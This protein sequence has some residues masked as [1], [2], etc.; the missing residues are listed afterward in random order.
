MIQ[1]LLLAQLDRVAVRHRWL[2][3][4]QFL[5]LV[6]LV[7]ALA[8]GLLLA[9]KLQTASSAAIPASLLVVGAI[10]LAGVVI[11][12][13][14]ASPRNYAWLASRVEAAF[15]ELH[16]QLLAAIQQRPDLHN[17]EFGYL[18]VSVMRDALQHAYRN[19]WGNIVS[20]QKLL[21]G[22]LANVVTFALFLVIFFATL[23]TATTPRGSQPTAAPSVILPLGQEFVMAVEPGTTE[24]ERGTSLLVLARIQGRMPSE[25][26]LHYSVAT[27]EEQVLPM[28][29]SLADPVFGGRIP[30]VME[31][32]EYFVT[33]D[34]QSSPK[35][36]VT[37][38]EYPKL[39]RADAKLVYPQYTGLEEKLIQDVRTVSAV[40]G[41]KLTLQFRLNKSVASARL[42]NSRADGKGD[43]IELVAS[44]TEPLIYE[45]SLTLQQSRRLKLELVDDAG[46][47]NQKQDQFTINVLPNSP[48]TLK[49]TFPARDVEVSALE[50]LDIRASVMDDFGVKRV[51]LTYSIAG[52]PLQEIVLSEQAAAKQKHELVHQLRL[53]EMKAEP[54]QL[55]SYY[56]WAE[57][58]DP[59]G[60]VRRTQSDMYFAEVR[61]FEEIFRQ[62][63]Q[64]PSGQQQRQQQQQQQG[65]G[66]NAQDAQQ[67]AK[68]Q[69]DIINATWKIIRREI[70][71]QLTPAFAGDVEQIRLSQAA[72][73]EQATALAEKLEDEKS[74]A[75]V[76]A[77]L[78]QMQ[79]ATQQLQLAQDGPVREPLPVAL[80]AEQ[81]AYQALLKLR[82]REHEVTRQQ[83]QQQQGQQSSQQSRSQ[84][85]REQLQQLDLKEEENRYETQ[86]AA[87]EQQQQESAADREN[88]QVL[89]RLRELAQRQHDL[90][91][92]LKELQSALEEAQTPAEKE[93]IRRQLQRLQDEERQILQDTDELQA[94]LDQ[95][96]NQERMAEQ[97]QQLDE[98]RD[99]V[100]RAS[101]AL[102]Q[103]KVGQAAAAGTRAEQQFEE[104][105]EEFRRRAADRFS[106]EVQQL[107]Q[108][109]RELEQKEQEVAE[110][111]KETTEVKKPKKPSLQE[112]ESSREPL[113][114]ELAEQRKRLSSLQD[115]MRETIERAEATEPILSERL[116]ETARNL[117]DQKIEQ[118]LQATERSVRQGLNQDAQKQEAVAGEGLRQLREGIERA[119]EGVL[120]D[121]TEA[122]RR[123]REELQ[124]LSRE[125]NQEL[126]REA[127]SPAGDEQGSPQP[128]QA[129]QPMSGE[130]SKGEQGKGQSKSG[131]PGEQQSG[132]GEGKKGEGQQGD[133]GKGQGGQP[134]EGNGGDG[135]PKKGDPGQGQ[136]PGQGQG[137]GGP[138]EPKQGEQG[139]GAA[140]GEAKG[141]QGKGS[142][143]GQGQPGN[144]PGR[145][146]QQGEQSGQ[147][148]SQQAGQQPG[149]RSGQQ[150]QRGGSQAN[151]SGGLTGPYESDGQEQAGPLTGER[152][153]EWS[154]RL[155]DVE[156]MVGD[157]ELRA[158]AARIR[159]R[160]RAVRAES[161]RHSAPPNWDLVREQLVNPLAELEQRVAEEVLKRTSK[162][163]LVPLDRD[164]V[165]PQYSE[166]TRK[167]YERLGSGK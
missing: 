105:R 61:P 72:A 119:A 60:K 30:V 36:R 26:T 16:T 157:P 42:T 82:A 155:R 21:V 33:A 32:L 22:A 31:P 87:Q 19:Q 28:P 152:F 101:E 148:Q 39:E 100:R 46:R 138:G 160:A 102:Q 3:L 166:K 59:S 8:G 79:R 13:T 130:P 9:W 25:A 109:A 2:R 49:P 78:E 150:N 93:E 64:P 113:A 122:L 153:R 134:G 136:Q 47:K 86:R 58:H 144:N 76:E 18:Q 141:G 90:N 65:Q 95:P 54:D 23:F 27:G 132:K 11:W 84:Q 43:P 66:Q 70:G 121:E 14:I 74:L 20:G 137:K 50:E 17:G 110:Q 165:P 99:Q 38:F 7:A 114:Q 88:R 29:P 139:K 44:S 92:R 98:T 81:A 115:Q 147:R 135:Q 156:E 129:G 128:G 158:D 131:Q 53:E 62:G 146:E 116:Y 108:S 118:A 159:E 142:Q 151:P 68:L 24:I 154:D 96:E 35:Y 69:K 52:Q 37:V 83:Q 126:Q 48:P 57:D 143:P 15:P 73:Q 133:T 161:K 103:E 77:V 163:A 106:E 127:P 112:Q 104:M 91:D 111:L 75:F 41:T 97:Q 55:L 85:Q 117:R 67:L 63:E 5:A 89:N 10:V 40:E 124:Q 164:P 4:F 145:G 162:K 167:Y 80:A 6:W 123:A 140:Q 12:Q 51:G 71:D 1:Q 149:Q 125:L 94:R 34:G 45:A 56:W 120:G 107:R